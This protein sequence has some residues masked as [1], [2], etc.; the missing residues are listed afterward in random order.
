MNS[1]SLAKQRGSLVLSFVFMLPFIVSLVAVTLFFSMY[2]Q[3]IVRMGQATDAAV[4]NCAYAQAQDVNITQDF[5]E[6]Y[7]PNFVLEAVQNEVS[8]GN[9]DDCDISAQYSF[10]PMMP[11]AL[12]HAIATTQSV[13]STG[14]S[15]SSLQKSIDQ[16]PIDFSLVLDISGSMMSDLPALKRIITDLIADIDP[17]S[18]KVRFSIVPF[19]SG[20]SVRNAPWLASSKGVTKCV[21]GLAYNGWRVDADKTVTNL[22]KPAKELTFKD[23]TASPWLDYCSEESTI[24][25]L[26]HDLNEVIKH[27]ER[28]EISGSTA[29]YQGFIWGVRT[30]TETWQQDW[31]IT[32]VDSPFLSQ[33]LILFTDGAD[34]SSNLDDLIAAGLCDKVTGELN[35]DVSFIGFDVSNARLRQFRQCAGAN[36]AVFDAKNRSELAEYFK[37]VIDIK[38]NVRI[39]LGDD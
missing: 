13:T 10:E 20:V 8:F 7:Q 34:S 26:T 28:L 15:H 16:D 4:I 5:L 19:A 17:D 6:Y 18:N 38:T 24:L 30:L 23:S 31:K 35:I 9:N 39:V 3:M 27:V 32:P 2:S 22:N 1:S 29:S 14:V 36:D 37:Q 25:P 11:A 12:P 21:D 33:R